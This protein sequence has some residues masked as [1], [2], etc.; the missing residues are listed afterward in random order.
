MIQD[1][2]IKVRERI[3]QAC[4]R[5]GRNADAVRLVV[6]S[7][8]RSLNEIKEVIN[9]GL[10]D[11]GENRLQEAKPKF[12]ELRVQYTGLRTHMV[13]HLQTNKVKEAVRLFDMIQSVD[14]LRLAL[15]I[16]QQ[17]AKIGKVQDILVEIKTSFETTKFGVRP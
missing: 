9:L 7:K 2:I 3:A 12:S 10:L 13:G 11:I 15:E 16:N 8:N 14:S 5:G 6:I 17:A 1:N 4:F